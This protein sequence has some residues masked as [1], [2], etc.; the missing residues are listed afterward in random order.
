MIWNTVNSWSRANPFGVVA[1]VSLLF[2]TIGNGWS[3]TFFP[4]VLV[5]VRFSRRQCDRVIADTVRTF[6]ADTTTNV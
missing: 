5:A 2:G 4:R 3:V 6:H 1:S